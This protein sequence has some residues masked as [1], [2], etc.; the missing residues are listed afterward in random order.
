M[1]FRPT[2]IDGIWIIEPERATDER[3][4][5]V[6]TFCAEAFAVRGLATSFAQCGASFN[7]RRGILRGLHWQAD[8]YAEAKLI[9]CTR[10]RVYDVAVDLRAR[11]ATFGTWVATELSAENGRMVYIP[12]GCAH[13]FQTVTDDCELAYQITAPHRPALARGLRWNDPTLAI[14]WPIPDPL[15]SP[16]DRT[17][18]LLEQM[19]A[20]AC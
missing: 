11:S 18:P 6:R 13:G 8:P 10:G 7:V 3:G 17:L 16:R 14:R 4:W 5:F 20:L 2:A 19:G 9:R 15:L 1:N 12:E